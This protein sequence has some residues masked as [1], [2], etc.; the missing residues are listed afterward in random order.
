MSL[1][2]RTICARFDRVVAGLP[3]HLRMHNELEETLIAVPECRRPQILQFADAVMIRSTACCVGERFIRLSTLFAGQSA[4]KHA[5]YDLP[6]C[7]LYRLGQ[8]IV[9][10]HGR[11]AIT[12]L[13]I[14]IAQCDDGASHLY[15]HGPTS[16][17]SYTAAFVGILHKVG[18]GLRAL[19]ITGTSSSEDDAE[20]APSVISRLSFPQ[21]ATLCINMP[22]D[23][24]SAEFDF[25]TDLAVNVVRNAPCI[26]TLTIHGRF[27]RT[28]IDMLCN[29]RRTPRL[30]FLHIT[31]LDARSSLEDMG[32]DAV[33]DMFG[34][35]RAFQHYTLTNIAVGNI[36]T[37]AIEYMPNW[38]QSLR[39][40]S[41]EP[42]DVLALYSSLSNADFLPFLR[43]LRVR[44]VLRCRRTRGQR[45]LPQRLAS[46]CAARGIQLIMSPHKFLKKAQSK[47]RSADT[48]TDHLEESMRY[49]YPEPI[50][51][52]YSPAPMRF[53]TMPATL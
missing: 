27:P 53:G 49:L 10:A 45:R 21:L 15:Q 48:S 14:R 29:F 34:N 19:R 41:G 44:T 28:H 9:S 17:R 51:V 25:M 7:T 50:E 1:V 43:R 26:Q 47:V 35:M 12:S 33:R 37:S 20:I 36:A 3:W 30:R 46:T 32:S 18:S 39:I 24:T 42:C 2:L 16:Y 8:N 22:R 5:G 4:I 52:A 38:I 11:N 40:C 13:N 23:W 6:R 31:Q